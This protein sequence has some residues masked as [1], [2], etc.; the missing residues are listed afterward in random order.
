M[1]CFVVLM[2]APAYT[3]I[4][5]WNTGLTRMYGEYATGHDLLESNTDRMIH[6]QTRLQW[7][8]QAFV[9]LANRN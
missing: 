6:A 4:G 7:G 1:G 8:L 3:P 5:Y 2:K 9:V